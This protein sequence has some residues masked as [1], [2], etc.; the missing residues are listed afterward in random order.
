VL[1]DI[2]FVWASSM[3]VALYVELNV[4]GGWVACVGGSGCGTCSIWH[5]A[6]VAA[7]CVMW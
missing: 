6:E 5:W 1:I 2:D 7:P 4:L 3:D